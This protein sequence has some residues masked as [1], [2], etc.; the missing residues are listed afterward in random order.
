MRP[1]RVLVLPV[2]GGPCQMEKVR[3]IDA[4]MAWLCDLFS[5]PRR[6]S[7]CMLKH[8]PLSVPYRAVLSQ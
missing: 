5:L 1:T 4:A 7:A 2:P 6:Y 8:S 3:V